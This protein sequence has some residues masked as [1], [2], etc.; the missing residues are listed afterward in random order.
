MSKVAAIIILSLTVIVAAE[1]IRKPPIRGDAFDRQQQQI[2]SK[3]I[4]YPQAGIRP[5]IPFDLPTESKN[6]R[7]TDKPNEICGI[8]ETEVYNPPASDEF[9]HTPKT[10]EGQTS[11]TEIE[12]ISETIET[13]E[14]AKEE[15][16]VNK[17]LEEWNKED[18]EDGD[19]A[20]ISVATTFQKPGRLIYQP[21][22]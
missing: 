14:E 19:N 17:D 9:Y 8:P 6:P 3:P 15:E 11:Q 4:G 2:T 13:A 12:T 7:V 16:A 20:V 5:Q 18:T 21:F 22:P 1:P 10:E